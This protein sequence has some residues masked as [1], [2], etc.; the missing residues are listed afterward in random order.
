MRG[1][2]Q[3]QPGTEIRAT[4]D[5]GA[6]VK[7]QLGVV[8]GV[9][10]GPRW[11]W[12]RRYVCTFMGGVPATAS[13]REIA[14]YDHHLGAELLNDPYWFLRAPGDNMPYGTASSWR[15]LHKASPPDHP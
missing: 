10:R 8:T 11:P 3:F 12:S 7:G 15:L 4:R 2:A 6:A 13:C 9:L 5:F 1:S 14:R